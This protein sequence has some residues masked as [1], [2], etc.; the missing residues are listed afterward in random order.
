VDEHRQVHPLQ[1]GTV[2][3]VAPNEVHQFRNTGA[4][5]LRFLCLIPHRKT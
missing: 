1:P 4:Q 5:M 3:F 2:V